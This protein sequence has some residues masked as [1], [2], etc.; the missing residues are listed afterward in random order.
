MELQNVYIRFSRPRSDVGDL[1]FGPFEY[2]QVTH[3]EIRIPT[4]Y[5]DVSDILAT[6]FNDES[7]AAH[8]SIEDWILTGLAGLYAGAYFSDVVIST[9]PP[10]GHDAKGEI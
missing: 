7:H 6:A 4:S 2:V 10:R 1:V 9:H 8:L 5:N 3:D